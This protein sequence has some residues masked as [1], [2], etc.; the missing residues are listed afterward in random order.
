MSDPT[1]TDPPTGP[2]PLEGKPAVAMSVPPLVDKRADARISVNV[3]LRLPVKRRGL[4]R[5]C[6]ILLQNGDTNAAAVRRALKIQEESGGQIGR[7]LVAMGGCSERAISRALL[8]QVRRRGVDQLS[9]SQ[10]ARED[11]TILGLRVDCSPVRTTLSLVGSDFFALFTAF[12]CAFAIQFLR[13]WTPHREAFYLLVAAFTLCVASYPSSGLYSAMALSAPDELRASTYATSISLLGVCA[14]AVFGDEATRLWTFFSLGVWWLITVTLVPFCRAFVRGRYAH[15]KWWG[16]PVIVLGAAKTGRLVVRTLKAQPSRGLKP[17]MLLDDDSSKHGTLRA[18]FDNEALEVR[19]VSVAASEL[20]REAVLQAANRLFGENAQSSG[21]GDF[22]PES[23]RYDTQQKAPGMFAEVEGVPIVGDLSIAAVLAKRLKIKYA[24]VAMPGL[25]AKRL[26]RLTERIAGAFSHMMMIPDLFG[27]GSIGAAAKDVGGVLGIEVRQQLLLPGPRL[28]KRII[29]YT[30]TLIGSVFVM[31]II[32][33]LML[34]IVIDSRGG[35]FY[36]QKRLGR[37]GSQFMA[38]KFRSMHGDGEERLRE[39][40]ASSPALRAEYEQFHKLRNDPRVTRIGRILRKFSLDELPQLFNVLK[41]EMSL[42]GPRP[43]LEREIKDMDA[44]E[45]I[46]LRATP[47]MTGLWQ[48][49]DRNST[50]FAERVTMDV[51]Y[52]RN[53]SPWIDIHILA[54]TFRVVLKGTG[55]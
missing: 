33:V 6:E 3:P 12:L 11:P 42:V 13:E 41:G 18:S 32:F 22:S 5:L 14:V 16:H 21:V 20:V 1:D 28:A 55:M 38:Y 49:S 54:R 19:S 2:R 48:V 43:Y 40:L 44:Q 35:P 46:I 8:E 34:L 50:G 52:V 47:G 7:I 45:G 36:R 30:L 27:L 37:D 15:R 10:A 24:V 31:P 26:L 17:V 4:N 29:D 53:W 51:H 25:E 9:L 23:L 39:V